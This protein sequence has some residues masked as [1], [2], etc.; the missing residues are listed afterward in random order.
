VAGKIA[1]MTITSSF[2]LM[3]NRHPGSS[4]FTIITMRTEDGI[5]DAEKRHYCLLGLSASGLTKSITLMKN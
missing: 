4:A 2:V 5:G 3:M 1:G